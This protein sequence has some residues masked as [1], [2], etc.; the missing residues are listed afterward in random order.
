MATRRWRKEPSD[1]TSSWPPA[2]KTERPSDAA[3]LPQWPSSRTT[4]RPTGYT[5]RFGNGSTWP[6][7]D[8]S[9][10]LLNYLPP[11]LD[12]HNGS[13]PR[14]TATAPD[15]ALKVENFR[16]GAEPEPPQ[17]LRCQQCDSQ[18]DRVRLL[19]GRCLLP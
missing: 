14:S 6:R 13:S 9:L 17:E 3:S 1:P 15:P 7:K 19:S 4:P 16:R 8:H 11:P 18:R 2:T 10:Q 5:D 12:R